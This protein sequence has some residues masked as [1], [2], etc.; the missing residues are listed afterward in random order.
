MR[1]NEVIA[2]IVS[3]IISCAAISFIIGLFLVRRLASGYAEA[4]RSV[5]QAEGNDPET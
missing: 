5:R 2:I 4:I 1:E 3:V